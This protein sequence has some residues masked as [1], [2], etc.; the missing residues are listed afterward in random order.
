MFI[1]IE[2][3]EIVVTLFGHAV[4]ILIS[5]IP[6]PDLDSHMPQR[7]L[8]HAMHQSRSLSY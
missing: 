6:L 2:L 8:G 4:L 1:V 5:Q 7:T 3:F